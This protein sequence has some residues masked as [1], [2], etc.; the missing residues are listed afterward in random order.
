M[1]QFA[2]IAIALSIAIIVC[3]FSIMNGF[4]Q[5]IRL[6]I[7]S[8]VSDIMI[9]RKIA[10]YEN[11]FQYLQ[12]YNQGFDKFEIKSD[13]N[14]LNQIKKIDFIRNQQTYI[15]INGKEYTALVIEDPNQ[16]VQA[17]ISDSLLKKINALGT[18]TSLSHSITVFDAASYNALFG[19]A[20]RSKKFENIPVIKNNTEAIFMSPSFYQSFFRT[21]KFNTVRISLK[22]FNQSDK[23]MARLKVDNSLMVHEWKELKPDLMNAL[24]L[25]NRIFFLLYFIMFTLLCAIIVSTNI[26][27]F[28][29]KRKDWALFKI[30]DVFPYSVERIFLYKNI[31]FYLLT[32]IIGLS[33]GAGIAIYSNEILNFI[34]HITGQAIDTRLFFGMSSIT[35]KFKW[36]DFFMVSLFSFAIYFI[37]FIALLLIF[38]KENVANFLKSN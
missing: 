19:M 26:A 30:L 6:Q 25:Q 28:K 22:D 16:I 34:G 5:Q 7:P 20:T 36:Q 15:T 27:F 10:T 33:L 14:T 29:E 21:N 12:S 35:W 32:T 31:L 11:S 23:I 37:N 3:T 38:R 17:V 13:S 9:Y 24:S 1:Q 2:M 4:Y 18:D 8:D